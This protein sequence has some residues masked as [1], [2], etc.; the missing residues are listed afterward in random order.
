MHINSL[1]RSTVRMMAAGWLIEKLQLRD[2]LHK[3]LAWGA[4]G[5]GVGYVESLMKK[6]EHEQP[7]SRDR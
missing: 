3:S 4:V 1:L 5:A 7:R 2:P 6:R